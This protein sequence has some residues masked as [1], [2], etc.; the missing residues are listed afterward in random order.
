MTIRRARPADL[1]LLLVLVAEYC[2]L[3]GHLFDS[4][5]A[6]AG[7]GP[8]LVD[9]AHGMVWLLGEPIDG[10]AVVTWGWSVEGGGP[11]ALLD[12]IYVRNRGRG[13]GGAAL[14]EILE[15][16]RRRG[17]RRIFLETE[18]SNELARR[19]YRRHGFTVEDSVWLSLDLDDSRSDVRSRSDI[20]P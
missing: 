11:E 18:R 1:D 2:A 19:F 6:S 4:S 13:I 15:D 3:E 7:L 9:D 17:V 16:C 8:V 5:T 14:D 20:D 12:E 10:Y